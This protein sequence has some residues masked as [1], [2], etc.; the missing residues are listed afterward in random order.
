M[1]GTYS[2]ANKPLNVPSEEKVL[3]KA[4][5]VAIVTTREACDILIAFNI[6]PPVD[7]QAASC[8][9]EAMEKQLAHYLTSM[10]Y[11]KRTSMKAPISKSTAKCT[12]RGL[13]SKLSKL[14]CASLVVTIATFFAL[15]KTS[16]EGT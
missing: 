12:V 2:Y 15:D 5:K 11:L 8:S 1:T 3:S 14:S 7:L 6:K 4:K 9:G 16:S 13:R 10:M